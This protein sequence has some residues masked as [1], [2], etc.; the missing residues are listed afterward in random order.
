MNRLIKLNIS[1]FQKT[2]VLFLIFFSVFTI[3]LGSFVFNIYKD[4]EYTQLLKLAYENQMNEL[5]NSKYYLRDLALEDESYDAQILY[6]EDVTT[7][8]QKLMTMFQIRAPPFG[9][10]SRRQIGRAS[11]RVR[12]YVL[13]SI[14]VFVVSFPYTLLSLD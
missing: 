8:L 1:I 13:V 9:Q 14:S 12:V 5:M 4:Y 10:R 2:R 6:L 3:L 11:C 7:Y